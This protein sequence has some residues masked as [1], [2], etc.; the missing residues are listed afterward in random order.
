MQSVQTLREDILVNVKTV[1]SAMVSDVKVTADKTHGARAVP[2]L[3]INQNASLS[4]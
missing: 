2:T 3:S 1:M 4:N